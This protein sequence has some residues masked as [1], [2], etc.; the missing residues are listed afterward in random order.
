[1]VAGIDPTQ[2]A[3]EQLRGDNQ[4][5]GGSGELEVRTMLR[6]MSIE[7]GQQM[8]EAFRRITMQV[9]TGPS[10]PRSHGF[11]ARINTTIV[12]QVTATPKFG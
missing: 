6:S 8:V 3:A 4:D 2:L 5:N 11:G 9:W 12:G 1:M 10:W 7:K